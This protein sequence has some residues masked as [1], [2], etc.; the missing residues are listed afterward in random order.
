MERAGKS[1]AQLAVIIGEDEVAGGTVKVRDL[2]SGEQVPFLFDEAVDRWTVAGA[3]I[4]FGSNVYI[5][6]REARS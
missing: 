2:G 3:A 1:G 6:H 5:A 4:I